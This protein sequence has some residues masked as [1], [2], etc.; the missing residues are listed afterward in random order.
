MSRFPELQ[1]GGDPVPVPCSQAGSLGQVMFV[2]L[3]GFLSLRAWSASCV[4]MST[5]YLCLCFPVFGR[6][7]RS[8]IR[9]IPINTL[10]N[11]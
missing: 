3:W 1:H 4:A 6:V 2:K 7:A 9:K 5:I 8:W 11:S 10:N